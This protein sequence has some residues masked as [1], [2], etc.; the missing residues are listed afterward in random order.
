MRMAI[1][2]GKLRCDFATWNLLCEK[3]CK[4]LTSINIVNLCTRSSLQMAVASLCPLFLIFHFYLA[5]HFWSLSLTSTLRAV[6][7]CCSLHSEFRL[8]G[9][10]ISSV[11]WASWFWEVRARATQV[12]SRGSNVRTVQHKICTC[13]DIFPVI[14]FISILEAVKKHLISL[15]LSK[16]F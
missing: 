4:L 14:F 15:K 13:Y 12:P 6:T 3:R 1:R 8:R 10:G 7:N 11:V 16:R 9:G 2:C 5:F